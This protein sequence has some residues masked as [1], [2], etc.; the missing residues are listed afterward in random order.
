[1][2][3]IVPTNKLDSE[4]RGVLDKLLRVPNPHWIRGFAGSG[5]SV[6]LIHGLREL[7]IENPR[8]TACVV[9]FTHSLNDMLRSGLPDGARHIP[10]M[11]YHQFKSNPERYDYIFVDEVQDLEA[12]ILQLLR[13]NCGTLIM[14]GDEE[15]SIFENRVGPIQIQHL[16]EP[17]IH[18]LSSV[19]RL[20]EKLKK[21]VA[22]ILPKSRVQSARNARLTADVKLTLAQAPTTAEELSWVWREAQ[23]VA[24]PGDPV[25]VLLPKHRLIEQFIRQVCVDAGVP[26]PNFHKSL[27]DKNG[28]GQ[29]NQHLAAHGIILRYLGNGFGQLEESERGRI[30]YLMT[31]HSAKGLDFDTVFLPGLDANLTIWKEEDEMERRLFYVAA[32][33]SR[34]NLFISYAG[35]TPHRFVQGMPQDLVEKI[36]IRPAG[37]ASAHDEIDD[38]F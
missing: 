4:Q 5:K 18:S 34:R 9:G 16:T 13:Q 33:R 31:Y 30:V 15:Q 1:M 19:Y 20:T 6:V 12:Y 2:P 23:R 29:A 36:Q 25:A 35:T 3:W 21:V 11:T 7:L 24:R 17:T 26:T 28:Y 14:A 37:S 22:T 32:T 27:E 38:L 8:A 10:V